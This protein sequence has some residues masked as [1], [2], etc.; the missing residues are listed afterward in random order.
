MAEVR[1]NTADTPTSTSHKPAGKAASKPAGKAASKAKEIRAAAGD[2][3]ARD[4][5]MSVNK[6]RPAY[7]QVADQLRKLIVDGVLGPGDRLPVEGE[8]SASFGVSRSTIRE[9]LRLLGSQNLIY[10]LRGVAGGTFVGQ[11]DPNSVTDFLETTLGLLRGDD[12]V[13]ADEL[14]E[15]RELLEVPAARLA[16]E[17]HS[18]EHL[19]ALRSVMERE[20]S[21]RNL[22][23][24]FEHHYQFHVL[25]LDAAENRLLRL[26]TVPMFRVTPSQFLQAQSP[27]LTPQIDNDHEEI[28]AAIEAGDGEAAAARM[29]AH[30][31]RLRTAYTAAQL[32]DA[33]Q[34]ATK[35]GAV[36]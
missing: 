14:L 7:Q 23:R 19:A 21:E 8:L 26:M 25:L 1:S 10:T 32:R 33:Q 24:R 15:A 18:A 5:S 16:A 31:T 29:R 36:A 3:D 28:L 13:T 17:R 30:L 27:P 22:Q 11:P 2:R 4:V 9:A 35:S 12:L 6:I 20:R 34:G